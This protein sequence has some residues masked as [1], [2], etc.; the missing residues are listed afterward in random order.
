MYGLSCRARLHV[1]VVCACLEVR[2]NRNNP[3]NALKR[4]HTLYLGTMEI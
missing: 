4:H 1:K 3:F 2:A